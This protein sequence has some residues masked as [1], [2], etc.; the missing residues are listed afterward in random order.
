M[1][2]FLVIA[3]FI[4]LFAVFME[5]NSS[6]VP[7]KLFVG[8]PFHLSLRLI[9]AVSMFTGATLAV[10]AFVTF[11]M[12]RSKLGKGKEFEGQIVKH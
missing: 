7:V 1:K 5:Q 3:V 9:I 11:K 10:A 6:P 12:I 2:W 4:F 8:S